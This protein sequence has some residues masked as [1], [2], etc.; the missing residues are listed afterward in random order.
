[1][2]A[3]G[4]APTSPCASGVGTVALHPTREHDES[5]VTTSAIIPAY[6]EAP[7]LGAVVSTVLRA[8]C[9]DEVIVVDDGSTDDTAS[10]GLRSGAHRV[11]RMGRNHG[12]G[13]AV[14]R[15]AEVAAGDCLVL[16][17]GDLLGLCC[18]H[19]TSLTEP[20]RVGHVDMTVG[21]LM[22]GRISTDLAQA[23]TPGLSGQRAVSRSVL[24]RVHD[25]DKTSFALEVALNRWCRRRGGEVRRV[26]LPGLSHRWKEEKLGARA[27]AWA[28]MRMY[29]EIVRY[30][31]R[32]A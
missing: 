32:S 22:D 21:L 16:L 9:V 7:T 18:S 20:V 29:W 4:V 3:D 8:P 23:L 19:V 31:S 6:N 11:L 24:E 1:M 14:M 17:D 27:G 15:G 2:D 13:T 12:K 5:S 28:R 26:G 25:L 10:V 30:R